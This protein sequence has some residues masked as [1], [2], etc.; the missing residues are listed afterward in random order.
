VKRY[1]QSPFPSYVPFLPPPFFPPG[2]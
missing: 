1:A 2:G